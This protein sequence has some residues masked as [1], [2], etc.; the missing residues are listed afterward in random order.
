MKLSILAIA[1]LVTALPFDNHLP[2]IQKV[3]KSENDIN[4]LPTPEFSEQQYLS[5]PEI[6]TDQLQDL[7]GEVG[8][9]ERAEKLY[10]IA[11]KST[12]TFGHPTRV[13]GSPG[14]WKT[15]HYIGKELRKLGGYFTVK[16]QKFKALDGNINS[17]S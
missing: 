17:F 5:L 16:Y 15:L 4:E 6:D 8:L 13:I 10:S 9:G 7:I 2:H 3:L 12:K 1:G 11:E 14:H